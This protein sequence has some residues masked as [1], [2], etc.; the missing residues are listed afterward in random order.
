VVTLAA[1]VIEE[2]SFPRYRRWRDLGA[3][4]LACVA[5]NLG[6]RQATAVWRTAGLWSALRG[7][8]Q[9]W[10]TMTRQGFTGAGGQDG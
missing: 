1:M 9:V 10:G 2:L 6:Y 7:Q 5:E 4:L 3:A 8:A